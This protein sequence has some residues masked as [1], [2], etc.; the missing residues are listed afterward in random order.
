MFIGGG[1]ISFELGHIAACAGADVT[2]LH[3]SGQ[4]LKEFD[5]FLVGLLIQVLRRAGIEVLTD[6][7]VRAIEQSSD[8]LLVRAGPVGDGMF[9]A[10]MVV[11]GAGRLPNTAGLDLERGGISS[12]KF[13]ID[14]NSY[15]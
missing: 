6:M 4:V 10:D 13:G 12:G 9:E 2:I 1:F 7:P 11:H 15:M 14:I 8:Q 5:P 3:R